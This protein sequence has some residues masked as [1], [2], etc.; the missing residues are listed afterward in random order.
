MLGICC[1]GAID[2]DLAC[3]FYSFVEGQLASKS[4]EQSRLSSARAAQD[5][6]QPVVTQAAMRRVTLSRKNPTVVKAVRMCLSAAPMQVREP[7]FGDQF[8]LQSEAS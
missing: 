7:L 3:E 6:Q 1:H 4:I 2:A 8:L 5:C